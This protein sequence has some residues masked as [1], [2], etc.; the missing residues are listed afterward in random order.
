M[1]TKKQLSISTIG[2]K[3]LISKHTNYSNTSY[4]DAYAETEFLLK[5][6]DPHAPRMNKVKRFREYAL[7]GVSYI[8][9]ND[10]ILSIRRWWA[11]EGT[12]WST[13]MEWR[14]DYTDFR[15]IYDEAK[16]LMGDWNQEGAKLKVLDKGSVELELSNYDENSDGGMSY[17]ELLDQ[18]EKRKKDS[19]ENPTNIIL[20]KDGKVINGSDNRPE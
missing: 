5:G 13:V 1:S 15:A 6:N 12:P 19:E 8:R 9:K 16:T 3:E 2:S 11:R 18:R 10:E 7:N 17:K 20:I 4:H 14:R